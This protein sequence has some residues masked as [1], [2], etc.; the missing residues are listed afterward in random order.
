MK[1]TTFRYIVGLLL[2]G[3]L[4]ACGTTTTTTETTPAATT[5]PPVVIPTVVVPAPA[6]VPT[7]PQPTSTPTPAAQPVTKTFNIIAQQFSFSP[8]AIVV[9]KGDKVVINVTSKDE[10][11]GLA[12]AEFGVNLTVNVGE[13]KTATFIANKTGVFTMFCSVY[14]GGGHGGM[15]GT[16]TVT[17]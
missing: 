2:M 8:G 3:L 9:K 16:L 15:R 14:C 10:M 6:P 7:T 5:T 17:E 13:T 1:K 12:I 4:A 11:H